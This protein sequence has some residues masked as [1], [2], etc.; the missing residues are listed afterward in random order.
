MKLLIASDLHGS[1]KYTV[2]LQ[3]LFAQHKP[4]KLVL[5]GDLL[6]HGPRN[7]LPEEYDP[8]QVIEILNGLKHHILAVRG[9]CEAEVDQMVLQ[10]PVMADY[11]VLFAGGP[12]IY[13][14]HGHHI[15]G[16]WPPLA[17]GDILLSGHTHIG[18]EKVVDGIVRL[19]P[20]S[21]ALPKDGHHSYM[22][23]QN[24]RFTRY[25]L[26]GQVLGTWQMAASR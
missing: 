24:G 14:M 12:P 21:L 8:K 5:L 2:A 11:M 17:K 3:Q 7:N 4:D 13:A 16:E 6:Y 9:N 25:N 15:E 22:L 23:L 26:Q 18:E 10:F 20:G 19:N 1:A